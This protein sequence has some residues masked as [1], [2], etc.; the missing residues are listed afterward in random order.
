VNA[1]TA[2]Y[3][4]PRFSE[5]QD[6]IGGYANNPSFVYQTPFIGDG[7]QQWQLTEAQLTLVGDSGSYVKAE[8]IDDKGTTLS[9]DSLLLSGETDYRLGFPIHVGKYLSVKLTSGSTCTNLKIGE[10]V[11]YANPVGTIP[12]R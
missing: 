4:W 2:F 6:S 5:G 10:V 7:K 11:L 8:V 3:H 9:T 12:L 1:S